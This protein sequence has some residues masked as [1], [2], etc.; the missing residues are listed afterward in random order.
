MEAKNPNALSVGSQQFLLKLARDAIESHIESRAPSQC[1]VVD[2]GLLQKRGAFVTLHK[3][4]KLRGCIGHIVPDKPLY[5]TV[6][7]VA[8][9]AAT[10][11]PRFKRVTPEE[12]P[13]IDLE[14]SALTPLQR[15]EHIEEIEIGLHG[16]YISYGRQ[17]GLLLPQVATE[18]GWDCTQLLQQTCRKAE[19]SESAWQEPEAQIYLFSAQVFGE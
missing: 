14:V 6:A 16:L 7:E 19:L 11:D 18:N 8:V 5:E 9:A 2:V 1:Q 3:S 17:S 15:L 10:C 12:M 4:G 13:A